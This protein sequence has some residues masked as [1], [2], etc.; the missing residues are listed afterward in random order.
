MIKVFIDGQEGT[1][2]LQIQERLAGRSDVQL[3]EIPAAQRKDPATRKAFLNRADLCILCLP[4]DA[5]RES[6]AL[7]DNPAVRVIDASTAHRTAPGW[8]YGLPELSPAQRQAVAQARFV[9]NPG[10][11]ATGFVLAVRPLVT[12]GIIAPDTALACHSITGYSGA[13]KKTIAAYAAE[14]GN[15]AITARPYALGLKHKH[16][17]EMQQHAGLRKA[18]IFTPI[19]CNFY[20]GMVVSTLLSVDQMA[21]P[22]DARS[23]HAVLAQAYADST[24]V[25]VMPCNAVEPL[26]GGAMLN[27]LA[28]NDTNKLELFVFGHETQVLIAARFDNLGKGASGAAV[29]NMNLMF[30]FA[31]TA[32][33]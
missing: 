2:G 11:H 6:V 9:S 25:K 13:G 18:P 17:P 3:L 19:I 30:G 5:A 27:P 10:C 23:V 4:D 7:L 31:E 1:T 20:K 8:V 15:P 22:G 14:A 21:R 16:L 33:L 28:L 24:F 32:G 26:D 12:A 29:Q